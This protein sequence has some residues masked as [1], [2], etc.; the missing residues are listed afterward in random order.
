MSHT[1]QRDRL[2]I[3]FEANLGKPIPLPEI[4]SLSVAQY[5]ARI[6]ELRREGYDIRSKT[7]YVVNDRKYTT[8]TYFGRKANPIHGGDHESFT[9]PADGGDWYERATGCERPKE[10]ATDLPLFE[11]EHA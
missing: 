9:P 1:T 10:T 6:F 2:R 7:V 11:V 3:L 4:L 8:F 5:G